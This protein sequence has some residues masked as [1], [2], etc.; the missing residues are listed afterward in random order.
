MKIKEKTS[1]YFE[2]FKTERTESIKDNKSDDNEKLLK[3]K[4]I[5]DELSNERIGEIYN[6]SKQIYFNNLTY[7]FKYENLDQ[8]NVQCVFIINK[9]W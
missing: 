9:K 8:L 7:K 3:Y 4:Q 2:D 6:A 5:F 1:W